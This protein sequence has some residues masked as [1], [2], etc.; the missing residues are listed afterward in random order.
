MRA[1]EVNTRNV[2]FLETGC[3]PCAA[4]EILLDV[5]F[6]ILEGTDHWAHIK[7]FNNCP[8]LYNQQLTMIYLTID[9]ISKPR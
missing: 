4:F 2:S 9:F 1:L 7:L 5:R 8:S 3:Y 6:R